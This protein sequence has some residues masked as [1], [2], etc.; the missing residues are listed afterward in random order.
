MGKAC[1]VRMGQ[2]SVMGKVQGHPSHANQQTL[3]R[4]AKVSTSSALY[5]D[6]FRLP[7]FLDWS[8]I[9]F[10]YSHPFQPQSVRLCLVTYSSLSSTCM[11]YRTPCFVSSYQ[12]L[13]TQPAPTGVEDLP[14]V[15]KH[16]KH[17]PLLTYLAWLQPI[18]NNSR[19]IFNHAKTED[20]LL[21]VKRLI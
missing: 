5:P 3:L 7:T 4:P 16:S 19:L 14:G 11:T 1:R 17:V 20:A 12:M 18:I 15:G 6:F 9:Q 2:A 8:D 10:F 21:V 13:P